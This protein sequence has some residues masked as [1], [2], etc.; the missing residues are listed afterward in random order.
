MRNCIRSRVAEERFRSEC[1]LN[2][3][4]ALDRSH[5]AGKRHEHTVAGG[6]DEAARDNLV[7]RICRTADVFDGYRKCAIIA[8]PH[9]R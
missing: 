3:D 5:N 6:I 8:V 4:D 9:T 7:N 2:F 1:G